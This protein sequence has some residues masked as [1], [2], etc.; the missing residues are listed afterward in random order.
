MI[1]DG[2]I[3][4]VGE[5]FLLAKASDVDP[6]RVLATLTPREEKVLRIAIAAHHRP[7]RAFC[8]A[9]DQHIRIF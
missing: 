5:A 9:L 4:A 6:A 1:E 2:R 8:K 7:S 3:A